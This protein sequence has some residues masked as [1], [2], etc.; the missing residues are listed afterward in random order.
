M[1]FS[2]REGG[3]AENVLNRVVGKGAGKPLEGGLPKKGPKVAGRVVHRPVPPKPLG[4]AGADGL[5]RVVDRAD[6]QGGKQEC[7]QLIPRVVE[8]FPIHISHRSWNARF[9]ILPMFGK[10]RPDLPN[11]G[12]SLKAAAKTLP[13]CHFPSLFPP[14]ALLQAPPP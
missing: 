13:D 12:K 8:L 11:I 14:R 7:N 4:N 1:P 9:P 3:R 6:E 2:L 5:V 10:M